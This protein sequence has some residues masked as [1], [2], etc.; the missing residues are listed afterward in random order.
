MHTRIVF[1]RRPVDEVVGVVVDDVVFIFLC[2]EDVGA[3]R[4]RN[5]LMK[6]CFGFWRDTF[7]VGF[8][9]LTLTI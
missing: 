6:L 3:R 7:V 2:E 9:I 1:A 4:G 8:R 5:T